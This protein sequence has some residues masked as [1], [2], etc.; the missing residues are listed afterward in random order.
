VI[1][2]RP[3]REEDD[4]DVFRMAERFLEVGPYRDHIDL[5]R[6]HLAF[7]VTW[8]RTSQLLLVAVDGDQ[9]IGMLGMAM[10]IAP[11]TGQAVATEAAWWVDD[12][13]RGTRAGVLLWNGAEDWA[14][15]QGAVFVQMIEPGSTPGVADMYRRRG[16]TQL[17]T[18]FQ[19]RL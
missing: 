16:Y 2:V 17:E 4:V 7:V 11:L 6:E 8:L 15:G 14:R 1:K 9:V 18:T 10:T 12:E 19:K 13:Y 5:S 3:A